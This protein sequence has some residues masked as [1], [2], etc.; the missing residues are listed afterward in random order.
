MNCFNRN[1]E[2]ENEKSVRKSRK[3][4]RVSS[5]EIRALKEL[6]ENF[7]AIKEPS[8]T[9]IPITSNSVHPVAS[10]TDFRASPK[11]RIIQD[12]IT[13]IL[14]GNSPSRYEFFANTCNIALKLDINYSL[15]QFFYYCSNENTV[16]AFKVPNDHESWRDSGRN[17]NLIKLL[18]K[19]E[20]TRINVQTESD[21]DKVKGI[22][23]TTDFNSTQKLKKTTESTQTR[24]EVTKNEDI[25]VTSEINNSLSI[26]DVDRTFA[27]Q[28]LHFLMTLPVETTTSNSNG[29]LK[30]KLL[31]N[32]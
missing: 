26:D 1:P 28:K 31:K 2:E 20:G 8:S 11:A 16:A 10:T 14:A 27:L 19:A 4:V 24:K 6:L 3:I 22:L 17:E 23:A 32:V 30:G 5:N 9:I 18:N 29:A 13:P 12:D 15:H 7:R 21:V 25:S